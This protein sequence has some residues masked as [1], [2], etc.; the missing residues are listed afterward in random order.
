MPDNVLQSTILHRMTI[1]PWHPWTTVQNCV[2]D[3]THKWPLVCG[4]RSVFFLSADF[5]ELSGSHSSD[6]LPCS[7]SCRQ[8]G[9][10]SG[11][12]RIRLSWLCFVISL[13]LMSL[14]VSWAYFLSN[15]ELMASLAISAFYRGYAWHLFQ[16]GNI[17]H[18][19]T[20]FS[21]Y[22]K[23]YFNLS[24]PILQFIVPK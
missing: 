6:F 4:E 8:T 18:S 16:N 20:H 23:H 7:L 1:L 14:H 15:S 24:Y 9:R 2:A 10:M 12:P 11:I 19:I 3:I 5:E 22:A 13:Y 17:R 21:S